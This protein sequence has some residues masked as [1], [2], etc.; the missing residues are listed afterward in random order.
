MNREEIRK[1]VTEC[2]LDVLDVEESAIRDNAKII[3][4]L[5]ADSLDLLHLTFSLEQKF[6]VKISPKEIENRAKE[7]LGGGPIEVDGIYT[8]KALQEFRKAMPEIPANEILEGLSTAAFPRLLRVA[9]MVNLVQ[10]LTEGA[11]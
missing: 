11:K 5:G 1:G 10:R 4:D 8:P 3:D 7:K 6:K 2:L 9:S